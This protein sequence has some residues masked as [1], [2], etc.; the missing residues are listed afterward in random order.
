MKKVSKK[1]KKKAKE[2]Y[3]L[4]MYCE[5]SAPM[6]KKF[7]TTEKL[8]KFIQ[9]FQKRYPDHMSLDSGY[10]IDYAVTEVEGEVHF[11]TDGITVA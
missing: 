3:H 6:I 11:F 4:L 9:D 10:W 7:D 8:S 5:D 1:T 2:K